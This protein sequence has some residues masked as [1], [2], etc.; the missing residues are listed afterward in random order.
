M[1]ST[2]LVLLL[3]N[4]Y[5]MTMLVDRFKGDTL[6]LDFFKFFV[7]DC[8][9]SGAGRDVY[10]YTQDKSLVLKVESSAGSF[11]NIMEYETWQQVQFTEQSKW[12]APCVDISPCG[13]FLLQK[14]TTPIRTGNYPTHIP[15]FFTDT[16][17]ENFGMLGKK[18][19][20]H[21][22]GNNLLMMKGL[23]NRMKK[24]VWW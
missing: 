14:R 5:K 16:K 3:G 4:T 12:F 1:L 21:D 23:S 20:C 6:A 9:G 11:Q 19:V 8:L 2:L 13:M 15:T 24:V 22:Y 18:F 7:G 17:L 10:E